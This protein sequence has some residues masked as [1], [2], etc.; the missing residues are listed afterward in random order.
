M[1]DILHVLMRAKLLRNYIS[2]RNLGVYGLYQMIL[3][4]ESTFFDVTNDLR[5]RIPL[6]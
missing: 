4:L 3:K 1:S 5:N 2:K 6:E